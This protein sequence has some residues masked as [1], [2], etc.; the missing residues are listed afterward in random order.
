LATGLFHKTPCRL[1]VSKS[2]QAGL[3]VKAP[4]TS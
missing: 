1:D 3:C 2:D 4:I